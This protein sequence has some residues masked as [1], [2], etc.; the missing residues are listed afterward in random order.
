MQAGDGAN[1]ALD[2]G[3]GWSKDPFFGVEEVSERSRRASVAPITDI[4]PLHMEVGRA[5]CAMRR[6]LA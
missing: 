3:R 5:L 2:R 6:H 4:A 1:G